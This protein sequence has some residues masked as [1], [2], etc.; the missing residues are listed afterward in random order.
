MTGPSPLSLHLPRSRR[1]K[2]G[3]D[4]ARLKSKGIRLAQGCL[5]ANWQV[6]AP[7]VKSRIGVITSR[8][9]GNAVQRNQARRRLREA[10]RLYQHK[11]THPVDMVLVARSSIAG[12]TFRQIQADFLA[13]LSRGGLLNARP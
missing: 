8:Q 11:F 5:V 4:F 9:I 6:Q 7:N 13:A 1:I 2:A 3:R 10:F 12:K